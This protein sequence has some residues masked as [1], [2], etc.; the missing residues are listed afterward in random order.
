M[1]WIMLMKSLIVK[2]G[3]SKVEKGP[4]TEPEKAD[5]IIKKIVSVKI[6]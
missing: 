1:Q 6:V 2:S 5:G 3:E 4:A